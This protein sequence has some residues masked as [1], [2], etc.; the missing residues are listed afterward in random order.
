MQKNKLIQARKEKGFSQQQVADYLFMNVSNYNRREKGISHIKPDE[1]VKLSEILEVNLDDIYEYDAKY[2][3]DC[4][5]Q[6][7]AINNGTQKVYTVP[8]TLLDSQ[9][10]YIEILENKINQLEKKLKKEN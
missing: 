2:H 8:K 7:I 10:K 3:I 9:Q 6:S 4:K 5:D 1:W